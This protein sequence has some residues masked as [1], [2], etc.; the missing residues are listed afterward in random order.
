MT[1]QV[2]PYL[3]IYIGDDVS[4]L[5]QIQLNGLPLDLTGVTALTCTIANDP[6]QTNPTQTF[7]LATGIIIVSAV[8]GTFN[9][10][11]TAAQSALFAAVSQADIDFVV[12]NASSKKQTYRVVNGLTV[13]TPNT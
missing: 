4:Q 6:S 9:L 1:T 11:I 13:L 8:Q 3:T 12:T 7:V 5:F 10:V 2:P